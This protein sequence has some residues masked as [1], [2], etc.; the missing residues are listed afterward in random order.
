MS[1]AVYMTPE[2]AEALKSEL[3][4]LKTVD[5]PNVVKAIEEARAHGDLKENAEYH[6]A[7]EQQGFIEGRIKQIEH[8][9]AVG[10]VVDLKGQDPDKVIFG[11]RVTVED[12]DSGEQR[13]YQIV[14]VD[15]ADISNGKINVH[16]PLARAMLGKGEGDEVQF[17][18]PG[19]KR[20]YTVLTIEVP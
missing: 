12:D 15:E 13:T 14:G 11:T 19:G 3:K 8:N 10:K 5:R 9:L 6:A 2:G 17:D 7:K 1:D 18:A 20:Y 16:S 4:R